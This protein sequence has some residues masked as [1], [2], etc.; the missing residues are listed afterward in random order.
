M[1][2]PLTGATLIA[3]DKFYAVIKG[4]ELL[5]AHQLASDPVRAELD[6]F[7]LKE[8]L[9]INAANLKA[10]LG[11]VATLRKKLGSEPS[12]NGGK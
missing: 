5:A 4:K 3:A 2:N 10:W 8:L 9:K 11:M 7:V 12:F 1:V 6:E